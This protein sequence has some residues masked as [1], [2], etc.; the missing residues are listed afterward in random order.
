MKKVS[1]YL[2]LVLMSVMTVSATAAGQ[3]ADEIMKKSHLAYYYAGDDGQ[4]EVTMTLIDKKGKERGRE[5]SMLRLDLEEGGNQKYYTYFKKPSDVSRLT[6]MVHKSSGGNDQRW[7]YVPAV[8]LVKPISADDKNS[9]FV[10]SDFSYEDV[11]GRHWSEDNHTF[12]KEGELDGKAVFVIES[13]PK[14]KYKGFSRKVSYIDKT[15]LLPVK[16]EYFD[17]KDELIRV[18]T[19]EKIEEI[20]GIPTVTI[21]SMENIKK[22]TRTVVDFAQITYNVGIQD[23][24]FTERYLKTPP[25]NFIK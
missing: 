16:E 1:Q 13:V 24:I 25:R 5:F 14:E 19:A 3:D 11:S 20:D 18:F 15:T 9:S 17:K 6:F 22:G 21:R 7:I 12:V 8:D 10:G 4:A 2:V 23:N